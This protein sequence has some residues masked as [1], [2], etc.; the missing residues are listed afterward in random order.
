M[1][2]LLF[3]SL[4]V[5]SVASASGQ[6]VQS[7]VP[8]RLETVNNKKVNTF[9]QSIEGEILTFQVHKK[10][11][12]DIPAPVDKIKSLTFLLKYDVAAV[13]QSFNE[14]DYST[15]ISTLGSVMEP[16]WDY[17]F[18]SN[19]WQD[20]FGMLVTAHLREEDYSKVQRA[21]EIL[22]KSAV[23]D[24]M[25]QGQVYAALV[26]LSNTTT[27]GGVATHSLV[28]AETL[29][30]EVA[31]EAAGL[32]L[33]A[34][35]ERAKGQPRAASK[36]VAELI[37]DH[38]NDMDWMPASEFLAANLY[39]D[40]GMTNSAALTARQVQSIYGG[41][42]IASDAEKLRAKLPSLEEE[43]PPEEPVKPTETEEATEPAKAEEN[44]TQKGMQEE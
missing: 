1:K 44:T 16:C 4:V 30:G 27:N 40:D 15:V 20:A 35:I 5:L 33:Q 38:G 23:P 17:M 10:A 19:N 13:E 37:A 31:S 14:G 9:L 43:P 12:K 29:R 36:I 21:S 28:L 22:Q 41:S 8:A 2:R 24:V 11:N 34:C 7:G 26:A 6:V 3:T 42:N 25:L 18:I 39:L 32:Y